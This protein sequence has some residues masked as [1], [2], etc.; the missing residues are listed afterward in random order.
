MEMIRPITFA[1]RVEIVHG[2]NEMDFSYERGERQEVFDEKGNVSLILG[3]VAWGAGPMKLECR[4]WYTN[5]DGSL[6]ANKGFTFL[7]EDGPHEL[8][9]ALIR[10]GYGNTEQIVEA[11][12]G[13]DPEGLESAYQ[14]VVHGVSDEVFYDPK[15]ILD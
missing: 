11:L 13:R 14:K 6:K 15:S 5:S 10:L 8:C 1:N 4:K 2:I 3:D 9:S 7:T 12:N